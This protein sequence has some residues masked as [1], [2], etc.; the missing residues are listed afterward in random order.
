MKYSEFRDSIRD[1]LQRHK[2]GKTW[3]ELKKSLNLPYRQPC[4][5]WIGRLELDIGLVRKD[6]KGNALVWSLSHV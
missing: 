1:E 2:E 5:E 3:F 6:K 4:P